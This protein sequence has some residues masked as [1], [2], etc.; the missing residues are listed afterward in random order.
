MAVVTVNNTAVFSRTPFIKPPDLDRE[1]T[2]MPRAVVNFTLPPTTVMTAKPIND[3]ET[4]IITLPIPAEFVY[5]L[6]DVSVTVFQDVA[7]AWQP[8]GYIEITNGVRGLPL[9]SV[10]QHAVTLDQP[11][12]TVPRVLPFSFWNAT[13][14]GRRLPNYLIQAVDGNAPTVTF[15]AINVATPAG[16]EGTLNC[17][18]AFFEYDIEQAQRF[19]LHWPTVVL[20]R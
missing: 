9:G 13:S 17:R 1:F 18:F 10:Q 3:Q 11:L 15:K 7:D 6:V 4:M 19:P 2:A 20:S 16:A 8:F 5:R 14:T 12:R